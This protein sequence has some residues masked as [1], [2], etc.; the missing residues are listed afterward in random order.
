MRRLGEVF[1]VRKTVKEALEM[2]RERKKDEFD[3]ERQAVKQQLS[4]FSFDDT[5]PSQPVLSET[6]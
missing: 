5:G 3:S 2:I 6:F 1:F 4:S